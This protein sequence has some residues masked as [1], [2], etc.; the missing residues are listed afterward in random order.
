MTVSYWQ[1][2]Y[3][4]GR[5][6]PPKTE[7]AR[8]RYDIAV[9]GGGISG[10][11][12]AYFLKKFGCD[13]VVVLEKNY[14]GYGATGRNAGFILSGLAE[15]YS[16]LIVAMGEESAREIMNSTM[17][18]HDLIESAVSENKID[19][20]Y[21]KCGSY[22]LATGELERKELEESTE[23]MIKHGFDVEYQPKVPGK[24]KD[25][26]SG[27]LGGFFNPADGKIDPFAFVN[28][29]AAG[30]EVVTD[31]E[32]TGIEKKHGAVE[33]RGDNVRIEAEMAILAV[34]AYAPLL[35]K[36]FSDL[37][38]P[39]RGQMLATSPLPANIL[40]ESIYYANF[41]YDYFRQ[42]DDHALIMGGLRNRFFKNETGYEDI[43]SDDLQRALEEYITANFGLSG[44]GIDERWGGVMGNTIDGLPLIGSLPHN[45]S[46]LAMVGF[47]GH[48]FGMG[49]VTARDL[50]RAVMTGENSDL[51]KR[52]SIKRLSR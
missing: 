8:D 25:R 48:G 40:G 51:L 6:L 30:I 33:I 46:V 21:D 43:I 32:V 50:A 36:Y 39:V 52:F 1:K 34:N 28:G 19:C 9:I 22:H 27:Y 2:R 49:M 37:V 12:T 26:L 29:L 17:E 20:H 31:F 3:F 41:G 44:F 42:F 13:N 35:D 7:H 16:R 15:P 11:A 18:N 23:M 5:S 38:F 47:N 45:S 4:S 24:A 14:I 10:I